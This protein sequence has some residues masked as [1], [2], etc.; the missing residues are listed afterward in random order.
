MKISRRC[1]KKQPSSLLPK[2]RGAEISPDKRHPKKG[3]VR[4][5]LKADTSRIEVGNLQ[6]LVANIQP[7]PRSDKN[8]E[9]D[10]KFSFQNGSDKERFISKIISNLKLECFNLYPTNV[11]NWASS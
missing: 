11:E 4:P 10:L 6:C 3:S 7:D 9:N 1:G 5:K 2:G 8:Y